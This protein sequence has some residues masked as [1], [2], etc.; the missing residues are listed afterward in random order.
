MQGHRIEFWERDRSLP[1]CFPS[2]EEHAGPAGQTSLPLFPSVCL[3]QRAPSRL[4]EEK[5]KKK[6]INTGWKA[7]AT[8][9][10]DIKRYRKRD[11]GQ[12]SASALPAHHHHHHH[13][14]TPYNY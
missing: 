10:I 12:A 3:L 6:K 7:F 9:L 14:P 5:I 2:H 13:S 11:P 1:P 4:L 8:D